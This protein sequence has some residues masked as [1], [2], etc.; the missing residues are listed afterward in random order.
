M[1][2]NFHGVDMTEL[3]GTGFVDYAAGVAGEADSFPLIGEHRSHWLIWMYFERELPAA[4]V[5][6]D[7]SAA[8]AELIVVVAE[9]VAVEVVVVLAVAAGRKEVDCSQCSPT[10]GR[11]TRTL[12]A[13]ELCLVGPWTN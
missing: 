4:A 12:V 8:V 9:M 13:Q 5:V 3:V 10:W 2:R 1:A 7:V 11:N 6:V